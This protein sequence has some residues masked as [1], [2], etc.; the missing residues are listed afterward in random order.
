M[1][2][3]QNKLPMVVAGVHEGKNEICAR[4][5]YFGLGVNLKTEKPR[6]QQIKKAVMKVSGNEH[7][8][9]NVSKLSEEFSRFDPFGICAGHIARLLHS[10]ASQDIIEPVFDLKN[11]QH[12][13]AVSVPA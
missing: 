2:G 8:K 9:Y 6:M 12:E 7:F 11:K 5:G 3:I 4:V 13:K 10:N 1:L